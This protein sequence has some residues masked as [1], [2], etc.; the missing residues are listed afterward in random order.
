MLCRVI[1]V[2][3]CLVFSHS[4]QAQL[5]QV[6]L[7]GLID[8][9]QLAGYTIIYSDRVVYGE[10]RVQVMDP[11]DIAQLRS[12]LSLHGLAL[13]ESDGVYTV[14]Q[15]EIV[16]SEPQESPTVEPE[17]TLETVIVTGTLHQFP[18]V[19][20]TSSAHSFTAEDLSLVPALASDALRAALRLPGMSTVGVSAKPR[21]RGGLQDELLVIQD[22]VELLEPFHLADYHSAYSSI[23]YLTI[24]SLD[25]YTGGFPSRY[26]NRMSGVMDIRNE[27]ANDEYNT[28]IGVS[29]FANFIHTRG[30]SG[31]DRPTEWLLSARQGDLSDLTDYIQSRSGEPEYVDVSA[32]LQIELSDAVSVSGGVVYAEDDIVFEDEE[33]R[34]SSQIETVYGWGV[35]DWSVRHGLRSRFTVSLLDFDREKRQSSFEIDEEDP[36]KGGFLNHDQ[37][38]QRFALRN[39]WSATVSDVFLEFGWQAES[40]SGDYRHQSL[41]DRGELADILGTEAEVERDIDLEPDGW[42]GGAYLQAEWQ[43]TDSVTIQPSLRWDVQNYYLDQGSENQLSPR[44]GLAWDIADDLYGRLSVGRFHQPEGIHE[45]QVI[46]GVERFFPPQFSDQL[47]AALEWRPG[48]FEFIGELYYKRYDDVK[49]RFENIFNP[50]V[51]LPEMEPDRVGLGPSEARAAGLDLE[52]KWQ[53][54]ESLAA[55]LRYSHMTAE[56]K[57]DD[58]WV[59]RRWSQRHTVNAGLSWQSGSFSAALALTWHSGWRTT[60]LPRFVPEDTVVPVESVL[61]NVELSDYYSLDARVSKHWTPGKF[62]IELYADIS[63]ITDHKNEAGIDFDIEEVDGG[64][65]L[66]PDQETLLGRVPSVGITLSF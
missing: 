20:P 31:G 65:L 36:D 21:I 27:W 32:R 22:G 2:A 38:I 33:E 16:E 29:S 64:Y 40:N 57:L 39:D 11:V 13:L 19:G 49:G 43:L 58:Q 48:D 41:I 1:L 34:A 42:S 66:L 28:D 61:N 35:V 25:V 8:E 37:A 15:G 7:V 12:A 5:R 53:A 44:L 10:Q 6:S 18:Y 60:E 56:D 51:L 63:N 54:T 24:E 45:L 4:G 50:F 9:L 47:I 23:D 59:D 62:R 46:D 30:R 3:C 52:A 26:G 17:Q 55:T 14:I